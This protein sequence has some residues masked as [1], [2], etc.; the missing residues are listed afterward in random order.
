MKKTVEIEYVGI[1]DVQEII[2][3]AYAVM[4]EGHYVSVSVSNVAKDILVSVNIILGGFDASKEFDY[5]IGFYVSEDEK[6]VSEMG[7]C[8]S[9]LKSLL[10]EE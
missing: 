1:E 2:D 4:R 9:V 5:M 8:K 6:D 7:K 3:D 10:A